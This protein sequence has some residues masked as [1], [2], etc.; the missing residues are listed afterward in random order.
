MLGSQLKF[1]QV[2]SSSRHKWS[3]KEAL[4]AA[5]V[6]RHHAGAKAVAEMVIWEDFH[7][8]LLYIPDKAFY[9][10]KHV[11]KA[12]KQWQLTRY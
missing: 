11:E 1:L 4:C 7:Q 9:G 10:I 12:H 5:V 3:L 8:M 6:S 2:H